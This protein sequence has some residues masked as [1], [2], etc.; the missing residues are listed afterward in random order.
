MQIEEEE[1]GMIHIID[2]CSLTPHIVTVARVI[3]ITKNRMD[4]SIPVGVFTF[5]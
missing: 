2:I 1:K 5:K 3:T 4:A